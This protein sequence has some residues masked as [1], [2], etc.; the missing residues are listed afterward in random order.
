MRLIILEGLLLSFASDDISAITFCSLRGLPWIVTFTVFSAKWLIALLVIFYGTSKILSWLE[1]YWI[2]RTT[3]KM[4]K[5]LSPQWIHYQTAK[6]ESIEIKIR[7]W[8]SK[9][10]KLVF[11]LACLPVPI[12]YL[13]GLVGTATVVIVAT[14][15]V[16]YGLLL[17]VLAT[18]LKSFLLSSFI[19]FFV[20]LL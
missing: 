8:I 19:Y 20:H 4:W 9:R 12:P 15:K 11:L 6:R 2:A 16:K 14:M 5:K 3:R 13:G 18:I 10:K 1:R 7:K 17:L